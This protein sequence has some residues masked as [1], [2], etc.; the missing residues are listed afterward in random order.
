[1]T[2]CTSNLLKRSLLSS[3]TVTCN[4]TSTTTFRLG[5]SLCFHQ[6]RPSSRQANR[7]YI[8]TMSPHV[9]QNNTSAVANGQQQ[10][11][12]IS[13][14]AP[15]LAQGDLN[16][17]SS[18]RQI[19]EIRAN[20]EFAYRSLAIPTEEDDP[21]TLAKYRPFLLDDAVAS[22]DWVAKLE[23]ATA[24]EMSHADIIK[25]GERLKVLVLY[26]SLRNR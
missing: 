3:V 5:R 25:T 17:T 9:V 12:Q 24:T 11:A 8:G 10:Q 6:S 7:A 26:G 13:T 19:E 20:P 2:T 14:T 15:A 18:M 16:N 22:Q 23:L 4:N 21:D 1:M